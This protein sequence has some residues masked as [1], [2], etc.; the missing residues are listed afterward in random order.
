MIAAIVCGWIPVVLALIARRD[1]GFATVWD[2]ASG[3]RVVVKPKCSARPSIEPVAE[4]EIAAEGADALGPYQIVNEL[5]P[6]R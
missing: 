4:P 5:V 3:T 6:E 1:N 2:L